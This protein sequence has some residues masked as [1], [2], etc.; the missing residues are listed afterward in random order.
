MEKAENLEKTTCPKIMKICLIMVK[1]ISY[2]VSAAHFQFLKY[3]IL[4][5]RKGCFPDFTPRN[6]IFQNFAVLTV[7]LPIFFS[8]SHN[9]IITLCTILL[10]SSAFFFIITPCFA[11]PTFPLPPNHKKNPEIICMLLRS[12][13][14]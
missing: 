1:V 14:Y 4:F 3:L 2:T 6:D 12:L 8:S 7:C 9:L 13:L 10:I 5:F 11:P